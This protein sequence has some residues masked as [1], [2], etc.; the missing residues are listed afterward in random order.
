MNKNKKVT[1]LIFTNFWFYT[2]YLFAQKDA[3]TLKVLNMQFVFAETMIRNIACSICNV[4]Y[5]G[6][7]KYKLHFKDL[8]SAGTFLGKKAKLYK[9]KSCNTKELT[10]FLGYLGFV[11][12]QEKKSSYL[13]VYETTSKCKLHL[14]RTEAPFLSAFFGTERKKNWNDFFETSFL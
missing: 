5:H 14:L 3:F 11:K 9:I 4:P 10:V 8:Y 13:K 1:A 2:T 6:S 12:N 7:A